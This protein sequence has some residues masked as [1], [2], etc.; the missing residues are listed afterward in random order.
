MKPLAIIS[1]MIGIFILLINFSI[2]AS[3]PSFLTILDFEVREH[4]LKNDKL[5]LIALD[6]SGT[7]NESINGVFQFSLNGFKQEISFNEG[8]GVAP[9][10]IES[11]TFLYVKHQNHVGSTGK[12]YFIY[13]NSQG[14]KPI[15]INWYYL[16]LIPLAIILLGYV[17]KRLI[18]LAILLLVGIFFFNYSK[19]LSLEAIIDTII[20]GLKSFVGF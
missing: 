19:G 6:S 12:L 16:I 9:N 18:I 15:F 14:L 4:L 10:A 13:K 2:Q 7:P 8:V 20:H 1:R 5:A 17:F 11:S 3:E